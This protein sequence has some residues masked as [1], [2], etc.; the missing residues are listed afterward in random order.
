MS[1]D[2]IIGR[3]HAI[4]LGKES[5]RGTAV[6]ATVW[7][8][9][10]D[11]ALNPAFEKAVDNSAYG[12]ID[13][14]FDSQT[15]KDM[16]MLSLEGVL[17]DSWLGNLLLGALG[18]EAFCQTI[19]L[20]SITGGT[21]AKGDSVS[22]VTSSFSGTVEKIIDI[23]GTDH[24]FISATSGTLAG[25]ETDFTNGTWTA[26]VAL[27]SNTHGHMFK[28]QND[29]CHPSFTVYAYDNIGSNRAPYMMVDTFG[30]EF[31]VGDFGKFTTEMIGQKLETASAQTPVYDTGS[32]FMAKH[33]TFKLATDESGLNAASATEITNLSIEISKNIATIQAFGDTGIADIY[34]Q[35]FNVSGSLE[36]I[37]KNTTFQ[38]FVANSSKRAMRLQATNTDA[39]VL[40][41]GI[42]P[43]IY[44]DMARVSFEEFERSGDN[45]AITTQS[46]AFT[47]EFSTDDAMTIEVLLINDVSAAY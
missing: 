41:T 37:Y 25:A 22:S 31:A 34:N 4:G 5:V 21:P 40:D 46:L 8:P 7:I 26:T 24:Y 32:P 17:R 45:D 18:S 36:A 10:Q 47:G 35:N 3:L 39:T 44:I 29:N 33:A 38:D 42:Y 11:G 2:A 14:I 6:A 1:C 28:R 13:E 23:G 15:V 9:K 27:L 30:I 19:T 12:V 43:A 16:S 20:T